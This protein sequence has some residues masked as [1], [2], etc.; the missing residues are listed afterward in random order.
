MTQQAAATSEELLSFR[1]QDKTAPNAIEK[2]EAKLLLEIADLPRQSRLGNV[3]VERW[4]PAPTSPP[5][6]WC[7]RR[8]TV[9]RSWR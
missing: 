6:L 5:R 2:L 9:T 1:R 4:G 7:A 3:K 8:P